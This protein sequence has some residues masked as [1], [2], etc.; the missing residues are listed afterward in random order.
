MVMWKARFL[1]SVIL[2][3]IVKEMY[4][5]NSLTLV[6]VAMPFQRNSA[7]L[8]LNSFPVLMFRKNSTHFVQFV[9]KPKPNLG[10]L[11]LWSLRAEHRLVV[12]VL[13]GALVFVEVVSEVLFFSVNFR[14]GILMKMLMGSVLFEENLLVLV[15]YLWKVK[16]LASEGILISLFL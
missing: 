16:H 10:K 8:V 6:L 14:R 9:L 12:A 11:W 13:G 7:R 2:W 15:G 5:E 3:G 4:G 1:M